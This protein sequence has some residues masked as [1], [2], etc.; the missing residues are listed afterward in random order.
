MRG[1][2]FGLSLILKQ[3]ASRLG[4]DRLLVLSP[5]RYN[6]KVTLGGVLP[7]FNKSEGLPV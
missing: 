6:D 3:V 7:T 5:A 2:L 1:I 4:F